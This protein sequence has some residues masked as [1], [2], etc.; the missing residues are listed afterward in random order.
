MLDFRFKQ[1]N[2]NNL[3]AKKLDTNDLGY[4]FYISRKFLDKNEIR[5]YANL[6]N[7]KCF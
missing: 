1:K 5:K 3:P 6:L 2:Y 4:L 7:K